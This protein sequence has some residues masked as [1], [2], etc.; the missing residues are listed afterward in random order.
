MLQMESQ[1]ISK[2]DYYWLKWSIDGRLEECWELWKSPYHFKEE[3]TAEVEELTDLLLVHLRDLLKA[4]PQQDADKLKGE[5]DK[6]LAQKTL[7]METLRSYCNLDYISDWSRYKSRIE[8][9][10][11]EAERGA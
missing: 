9:Q 5:H 2:Q 11:E 6:F 3:L 10:F 1:N 7:R 8:V 4:L